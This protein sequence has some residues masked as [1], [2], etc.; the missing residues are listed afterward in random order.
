[1]VGE[2]VEVQLYR[3]VDEINHTILALGS[4]DLTIDLISQFLAKQGMRLSS[5][6]VGSLG[7]LIALRR[8][9]AHL[10]G[11]HLLDPE[12]G[13]YNLKYIE[14][15]VPDLAV[16]VIA[17]VERE[18]GLI[19]PSGNPKGVEDLQ[20]LIRE[21]IHFVN[22]QRGS[23]T[24]LLLDYHLEQ[25]EVDPGSISGYGWEEFTH[26][27]VAA[28]VS[29]G[30]ADV[31]LGVRGAAIALELDF[32]PLFDERYDIVIPK[33]LYDAPLLRPL[34]QL[35]DE[36]EFRK[37]VEAIPGYRTSVMGNVIAKINSE[38]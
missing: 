36:P 20:D 18:Q 3:S 16:I 32:I 23:G 17:L 24:R 13:E 9:E 28:A 7:G 1:M 29:S 6:N 2:E 25:S 35:L 38:Y 33:R 12:S 15:Y 34:I 21:D 4:H 14:E 22:R 10:C 30:R 37:T 19:L 5:S 27:T 26:L 11:S 31:G 8:N